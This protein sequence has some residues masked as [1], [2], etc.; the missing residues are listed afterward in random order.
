MR[1][2]KLVLVVD[3]ILFRCYDNFKRCVARLT[4][5]AIVNLAVAIRT[6]ASHKARIIGSIIGQAPNVMRLQIKCARL[7]CE[8]LRLLAAFAHSGSTR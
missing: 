6:Y 5:D 3:R 7:G 2:I 8:R 1:T 4:I